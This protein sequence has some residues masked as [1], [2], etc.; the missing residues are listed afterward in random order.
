MRRLLIVVTVLVLSG[1]LVSSALAQVRV[2]KHPGRVAA[3]HRASVTVAVSPTGGRCTIAVYYSTAPSR[4]AGLGAK[5]GI[6]I[7]WT[8]R[9]GSN[10]KH[11]TWPVRIDC[12]KA[13]KLRRP[14]R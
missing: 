1:I 13:G 3:G 14:L 11:G 4:A 12:G 8:W 5:R 6:S 10:T 2:M 9:I 7:T